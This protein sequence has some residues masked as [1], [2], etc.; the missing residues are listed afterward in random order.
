M[1]SVATRPGEAVILTDWCKLGSVASIS[2]NICPFDSQDHN[3]VLC[4]LREQISV[5]HT[6]QNKAVGITMRSCDV[7]VQGCLQLHSKISLRRT[8]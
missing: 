6:A 1:K 7:I 8:T 3:R 5:S 2:K 4:S